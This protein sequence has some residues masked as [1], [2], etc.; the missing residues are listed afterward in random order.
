MSLAT[1]VA[2]TPTI[3]TVPRS[4]AGKTQRYVAEPRRMGFIETL[5]RFA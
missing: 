4:V 5:K 3:V 2:Q 1:V